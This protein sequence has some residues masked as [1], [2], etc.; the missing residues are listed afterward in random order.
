MYNEYTYTDVRIS[1]SW[2]SLKHFYT[3]TDLWPSTT[4]WNTLKAESQLR[5]ITHCNKIVYTFWCK[6]DYSIFK[7]YGMLNIAIYGI[8]QNFTEIWAV[9]NCKFV[10]IS[11]GQSRRKCS[12]TPLFCHIFIAKS[13]CYDCVWYNEDIERICKKI[14]KC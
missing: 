8:I 12:I 4:K 5:F 3:Q 10:C 6:N 2:S 1:S 7:S 11:M 9:K 13:V 14:K